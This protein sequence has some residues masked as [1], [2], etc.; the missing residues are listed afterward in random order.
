M[1][2][3][4]P[5]AHGAPVSSPA[6]TSDRRFRPSPAVAVAAGLV[7]GAGGVGIAWA[8]SGDDGSSGDGAAD[9]ARRACVT[10]ESFDESA[11]MD[12]D[13]QRNIAFNRLGGATALSAAAAAGDRE[14]KPLADAVQQVLNHQ[15]RADDF[16]DPGFRKDLKAA[17]SLCDRL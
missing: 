7:L 8:L 9:D 6:P 17:R 5:P 13:A 1:S 16:T 14:Y 3:P 11:D 12:N 15:M 10:L 4:I 2:T